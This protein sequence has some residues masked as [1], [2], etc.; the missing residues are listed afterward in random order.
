[1]ANANQLCGPITVS[2]HGLK[3]EDA[4]VED[5]DV[6]KKDASGSGYVM[7]TY[8]SYSPE[9]SNKVEKKLLRRIDLRIMPLV[10]IIYIFSYLDRNSVSRAI[11]LSTIFN[12]NEIIRL[13]R[14][15]C[16]VCRRILRL[17][18]QSTT[19]L[20]LYS[21]LDMSLCNYRLRC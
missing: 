20:L 1:M 16:M 14:L 9:Y 12:S 6:D 7:T 3:R 17:L 19:L 11:T 21:R 5:I 13:L 4:F 2:E 10:V 15:V 18:A 8:H